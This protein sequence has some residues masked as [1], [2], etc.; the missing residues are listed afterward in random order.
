MSNL[1]NPARDL[2]SAQPGASAGLTSLFQCGKCG[3]RG[4]T[5]GRRMR[6]VRGMRTWVCA[7][8]VQRAAEKAAA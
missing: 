4:S 6:Y 8:C 2:T 5:M 7:A 1:Y 3:K